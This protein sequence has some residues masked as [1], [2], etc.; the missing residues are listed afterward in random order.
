MFVEKFI[1]DYQYN[2]PEKFNEKLINCKADEDIILLMSEACKSLEIVEG[3]KFL[4][5]TYSKIDKIYKPKKKPK[6]SEPIKED[7][8]A[9]FDIE[10]SRLGII[11]LKFQVTKDDETSIVSKD[12]YFPELI[13]NK[14]FLINGNRFFPI[15]QL[16]DAETYRTK[17]SITLKTLMMP[18]I[19]RFE[20]M[21]IEVDNCNEI[22][23]GRALTL[24]L[25]KNKIYIFNYYFAKMGF[26]NTLE[27][28]GLDNV[29]YMSNSLYENPN[30]Y[31][32]LKLNKDVYLNFNTKW[33]NEY[34]KQNADIIITLALSMQGRMTLDKVYEIEY[35]Q[36]KLG[37][38]FTKNNS[39]HLEK[40]V[41]ILSSFERILDET[42]KRILRIDEEY[43]QDSYSIVKFIV[44][45]YE[46]LLRQDNMDLANKRLR[47]YEYLMYPLIHKLSKS[48]YRILNQKVVTMK[49]LKNSFNCIQKGFVVK[50]IVNNK[51]V[52]YMNNVNSIDLF[53]NV[54]KCSINGPQASK[55]SGGVSNRM[56]AVHPSMLGRIDT[57]STSAGSPGESL[58]ITPFCDITDDL[59]F[60]KEP[61]LKFI[62]YNDDIDLDD[63]YDDES[64]FSSDSSDE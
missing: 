30:E 28:F 20:N 1:S 4:S 54:L 15:F 50:S 39:N 35:W 43:K 62:K 19:V 37:S 34:P 12:V 10:E 13:D 2:N 55:G 58:T 38:N 11:T 3:I 46:T 59:H 40:G 22:F 17:N 16:T 56:R 48:V 33:F 42:T 6:N 29:I 41:S 7:S 24:D 47:L 61:K 21:S 45:N 51:L 18:D 9:D 27:Y 31:Y 23:N 49:S 32:S 44:M 25:F 60:T 52:R 5:C 26:K 8:K 14:Y 57:C 36:R 53:S 64:E 63:D